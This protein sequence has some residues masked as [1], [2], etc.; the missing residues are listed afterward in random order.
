MRRNEALALLRRHCTSLR[1]L[2][3]GRLYLYGSVARDEAGDASDVDLLVD[4]EREEFS[5]FDLMRVQDT[6]S[7]VLGC[8]AE[9]HDYRGLARAPDFRSRVNAELINVF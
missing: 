9:L 6:C 1:R 5:L 4:P 2:G 7:R 8:T 3:V